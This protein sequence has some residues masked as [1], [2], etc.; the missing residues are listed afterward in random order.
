MAS[1]LNGDGVTFMSDLQCHTPTG[2]A[3]GDENL[4][5]A[6][7]KHVFFPT[8]AEKIT[9]YFA[10]TKQA[11]VLDNPGNTDLG[12]PLENAD[13][14]KLQGGYCPSL[15]KTPWLSKDVLNKCRPVSN[16]TH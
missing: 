1:P 7:N 12:E 10:T 11:C 9:Q 4:R 13:V 3:T 15:V 16:L 8:T 5:F 14:P 6:D 2:L